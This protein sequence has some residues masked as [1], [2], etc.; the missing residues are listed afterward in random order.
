M[1]NNINNANKEEKKYK[2]HLVYTEGFAKAIFFMTGESYYVFDDKYRP[3]RKIYSFKN[4][5]KIQNAIRIIKKT[6]KE[7]GIG[8]ET[9]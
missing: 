7:N 1:N 6:R 5:E 9:K 2:Y 3:D 4:S 8:E